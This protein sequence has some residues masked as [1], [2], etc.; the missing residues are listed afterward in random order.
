MPLLRNGQWAENNPWLRLEDDEPFHE[1]TADKPPQICSLQRF[2]EHAE[3]GQF[4]VSGVW[5]KSDDDVHLLTPYLDNVQLVVVDFPAFTDGRGYTQARVLRT[6]L[7]FAGELRATGDVR[8]D[9]M[10][11]MAR[12]GIDTFEFQVK[13]DQRLIDS[14]LSRFTVNYQPSYSLPIAG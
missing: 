12:A 11:F 6:Q 7:G 4:P 3:R 2:T 5:L 1:T 9:Q 14:I 8:A 10:L 13:P